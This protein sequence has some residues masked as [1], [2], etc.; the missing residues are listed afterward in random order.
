MNYR[1]ALQLVEESNLHRIDQDVSAIVLVCFFSCKAWRL[2]SKQFEM[3]LCDGF[4]PPA[5]VDVAG[6]SVPPLSAILLALHTGTKCGS[7]RA[8]SVFVRYPR[9]QVETILVRGF[10]RSTTVMASRNQTRSKSQSTLQLIMAVSFFSYL[11]A[12]RGRDAAGG[13]GGLRLTEAAP[14]ASS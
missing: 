4:L 5:A 9:S 6:P 8:S 13:R 3:F 2:S 12:C 11:M 7:L 1:L 10:W 14:L